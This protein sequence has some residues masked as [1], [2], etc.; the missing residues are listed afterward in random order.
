MVF[1]LAA[2]SNASGAWDSSGG[3]IKGVSTGT[4]SGSVDDT[5][6]SVTG[7]EVSS[8]VPHESSS[9]ASGSGA[10]V[11]SVDCGSESGSDLHHWL[12]P[13]NRFCRRF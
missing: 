7:S 9:V 4:G 10:A 13:L 5:N 8:A 6:S 12:F 2:A 3:V 1:E 11:G